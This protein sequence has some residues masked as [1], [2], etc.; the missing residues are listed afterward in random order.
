[1]VMPVLVEMRRRI[2]MRAVLPDHLVIRGAE[3]VLLDCVRRLVFGSAR[4]ENFAWPKP[5]HTGVSGDEAVGQVD[6]LLRRDDL[7]GAR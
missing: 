2:D 6:E 4:G 5:D 7:I 3:A 1:M